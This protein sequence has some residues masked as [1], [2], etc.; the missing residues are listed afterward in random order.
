MTF[1]VVFSLGGWSLPAHALFTFL[2]Y[3]V[4][5]TLI[6]RARRKDGDV[7]DARERWIVVLAAVVGGFIGARALGWPEGKTVVGGLLGGTV[8]VEAAKRRM[9]IAQ[10]TGEMLAIPLAIG[11]AI[12]RIGCF[13]AGLPDHTY[14]N[15]TAMFTGVD[16]GDGVRRHPTQLYEAIVL[17]LLAAG[18]RREASRG[19]RFALFLVGYCAFR[20][21]LEFLKP[22]QVI[23]GMSVIQWG[24]AAGVIW[25]AGRLSRS[26]SQSATPLPAD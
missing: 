2:G 19:R 15:A 6:L 8:A 10:S 5:A 24:S 18:L 20:F 12:G 9:G 7:L 22:R 16:F 13:L 26:S 14:G 17:L 1:P 3:V 23:A 4:A 11:I 25:F 21:G